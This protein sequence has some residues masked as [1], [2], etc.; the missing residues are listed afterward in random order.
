[1]GR[2]PLWAGRRVAGLRIS[3]GDIV[4][5][6]H[7]HY[8]ISEDPLIRHPSMVSPIQELF[9]LVAGKNTLPQKRVLMHLLSGLQ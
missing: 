3:Q 6:F 4:R 5:I 2:E 8:L 7:Q 9:H 1:M